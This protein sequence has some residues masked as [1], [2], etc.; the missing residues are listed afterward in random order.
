MQDAHWGIAIDPLFVSILAYSITVLTA[1]VVI[2]RTRTAMSLLEGLLWFTLCSMVS[3]LTYRADSHI[4]LWGLGGTT[5][6]NIL[7]YGR[8]ID[9]ESRE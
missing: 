4:I 5:L 8:A 2:A 6:M 3:Y 1:I 9:I 7:F